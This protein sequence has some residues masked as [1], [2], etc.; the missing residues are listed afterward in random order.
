MNEKIVVYPAPN[1]GEPLSLTVPPIGT[2]GEG[3]VYSAP[4]PGN[5]KEIAVKVFSDRK[6]GESRDFL[7]RKITA[8]VEMGRAN[9]KALVRH[10]MLAWPQLSVYDENGD[11]VGYAM[12]RAQGKP[13][14]RLAHPMLFRKHFPG[15]DREK[16]ALMLM[17]L[18]NAAQA[19]HNH[20]V[21]IGDVNPNNVLWDGGDFPC[22]I[23]IDSFQVDAL[24][25]ERFPCPVGR[26]EMTPPEHLGRDHRQIR[27]DKIV[28]TRESDFFSLAI[29]VFQCMMLG[30]HPYEHIGGGSP[31]ENMRTGHFPYAK[32][33]AVPGTEGGVP[34][35][36]WHKIWSHYT[37]NLKR[38]FVRAF[39]D[40]AGDPS[41]RPSTEEWVKELE[42][43]VRI[44]NH[45]DSAPR[46]GGA[47]EFRHSRDMIPPEEKP[48]DVG[49]RPR[50]KPAPKGRRKTA[51]RKSRKKTAGRT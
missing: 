21:F 37:Y 23:D 45:P 50:K 40:G 47:P 31:V 28:R 8:M 29:L 43:Y 44:L 17:S 26:P 15:M 30:R 10:P 38:A 18:L 20:G 4:L 42:E 3:A 25:G 22:W 36:P 33:G 2:G 24:N 14:S 13:L 48:K 9:G 34:M 12:K 41:R 5:G 19:L 39:V 35:G 46:A 7:S 6:L 16:V 51:A 32:G 1:G 27:F 49:T 11:W